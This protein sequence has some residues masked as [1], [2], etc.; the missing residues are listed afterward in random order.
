MVGH[1][2]ETIFSMIDRHFFKTI[3]PSGPLCAAACHKR[4]YRAIHT[5]ASHSL[6]TVNN[7][8]SGVN[9]DDPEPRSESGHSVS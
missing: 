6:P 9:P 3:V 7:R 8:I 5:R 4:I 2:D 1:A